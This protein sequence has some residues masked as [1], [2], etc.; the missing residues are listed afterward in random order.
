MKP[1]A[2]SLSP[3]FLFLRLA[4]QRRQEGTLLTS[5][6]TGNALWEKSEWLLTRY[7]HSFRVTDKYKISFIKS[8]HAEELNHQIVLELL[9]KDFCDW[10]S[11]LFKRPFQ[12]HVSK[13]IVPFG[14]SAFKQWV[15]PTPVP[16]IA[17]ASKSVRSEKGGLALQEQ[18]SFPPLTYMYLPM[19]LL[20][21]LQNFLYHQPKTNKTRRQS[22]CRRTLCR[23]AV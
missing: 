17:H 15:L 2:D 13:S 9:F 1:G 6:C 23:P 4:L 12:L 19:V 21:L 20:K 5:E 10:F 7:P 11:F 18:A 16:S 14:S 3:E 8:H 22:G